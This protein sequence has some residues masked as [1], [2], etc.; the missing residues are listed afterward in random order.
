MRS[1]KRFP[2][3][4]AGSNEL[5]LAERWLEVL[6]PELDPTKSHRLDAVA[7]LFDKDAPSLRK[8]IWRLWRKTKADP[9]GVRRVRLGGAVFFKL[10]RE[11]RALPPSVAKLRGETL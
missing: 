5:P 11:W 1:P 8:Q 3:P 6:M 4:D 7:H 10:G 2:A 9:D